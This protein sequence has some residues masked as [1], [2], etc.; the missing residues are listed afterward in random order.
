MTTTKTRILKAVGLLAA[1]LTLCI[2]GFAQGPEIVYNNTTTSLGQQ[3][4]SDLEFG[5]QVTLDGANRLLSQFQFEYFASL[6]PAAS[7]QGLLRI[8]QNNGTGGAPNTLVFESNPFT[9]NN[10]FNQVIITG[11]TGV[12]LP[13]TFTWTVA[14]AGLTGSEAGGLLLYNPPSFGS[15]ADDF[16][17]KNAFGVWGLQRLPGSGSTANFGAKITAVPEP[18]TV[19][20]AMLGGFCYL[21]FLLFRR[22]SQKVA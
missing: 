8:Y 1:S 10:S 2:S 12:T 6:T 14:F 22:H 17:Q 16:W 20:I 13:S 11:I 4:T 18:G 3:Y 7:K 19:Q 15:S 9:L 21:G 5:D